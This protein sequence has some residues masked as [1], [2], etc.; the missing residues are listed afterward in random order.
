[1]ADFALLFVEQNKIIKLRHIF[2]WGG[3]VR[4]NKN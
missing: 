2:L 1:M 3:G 4:G